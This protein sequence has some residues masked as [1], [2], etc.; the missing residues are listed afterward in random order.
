MCGCCCC[1]DGTSIIYS[2]P[3]AAAFHRLYASLSY[4]HSRIIIGSSTTSSRTRTI[5]VVRHGR[6][7][8]LEGLLHDLETRITDI[9][10]QLQGLDP[11]FVEETFLCE[12]CCLRGD[13]AFQL[14]NAIVELLLMMLLM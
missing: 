4:A 3:T 11:F 14:P 6:H 10:S 5:P 12:L 13:L 9:E 8:V 1:C 2:S 7:V